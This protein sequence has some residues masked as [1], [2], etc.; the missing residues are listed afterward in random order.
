ML[1]L[2]VG[3]L[4]DAILA[5]KYGA[6]RLELNAALEVGG[7]T[8]SF[9]LVAKV[10]EHVEIPVV[11]MV[12]P[13]VAGFCYSELEIVTIL[14]DIEALLALNIEA[15]AVGV[16]HSDSS[17][18]L[19]VMK[20]IVQ[21]CH[22]KGKKVVFH[23][24]FDVIT[25]QDIFTITQ[26]LIDLGVD[27]ILTS[28]GGHYVTDNLPLLAQLQEKFRKQITFVA[29]SGVTAENYEEICEQT[30]VTEVHGSFSKGA[31]DM[32]TSGNQVDFSLDPEFDYKKLDIKALQQC[33]KPYRVSNK[34]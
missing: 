19:P 6:D 18:N 26:Q 4:Q 5:Q 11:V 33:K 34:A 7:L 16:L 21:R 9:G 24:A 10:V 25:S 13:R 29:A 15:I 23:R 32:T 12:R 14:Q 1:E 22:Q 28:A 3:N 2:C 27:R 8:P 20:K 30:G 17:I 31:F